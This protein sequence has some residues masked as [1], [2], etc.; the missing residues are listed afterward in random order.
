MITLQ[1]VW[2][3]VDLYDHTKILLY[4]RPRV[5]SKVDDYIWTL[6]EKNIVV[7]RKVMSSKK[8]DYEVTIGLRFYDPEKYRWFQSSPYHGRIIESEVWKETNGGYPV[9]C[10]EDGLVRTT[11]FSPQK[12]WTNRGKKILSVEA[13]SNLVNENMTPIE[14]ANILYDA[15]G[16]TLIFNFKKLKKEEFDTLKETID[17]DI[18]N[19]FPFPA[20]F[21]EQN[22]LYD[23]NL[24][25]VGFIEN[26]EEKI[27]LGPYSIKELYLER[28]PEE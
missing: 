9:E 18:I 17:W 10:F 1:R 2:A 22:Y 19:G 15:I 14:Y 27:I 5:S 24:L 8:Y 12:I 20:A 25:K 11:W 6:I 7:P 26:N 21:S 16:A 13:Y 23:E 3:N 28:Y 4:K